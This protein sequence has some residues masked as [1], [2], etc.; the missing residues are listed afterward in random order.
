MKCLILVQYLQTAT[1]YEIHLKSLCHNTWTAFSF[2][3]ITAIQLVGF[4]W[5]LASNTPGFKT[6]SKS[7]FN[8]FWPSDLL[9]N[10]RSNYWLLLTSNS[11]H[12]PIWKHIIIWTQLDNIFLN[13]LHRN[14]A[15]AG[16]GK[17]FYEPDVNDDWDDEDPDDDLE[18]WYIP[19]R[20]ESSNVLFS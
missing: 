2:T 19:L 18:I 7:Y 9:S 14:S 15:G 1:E 17:I 10:Y 6:A 16:R 13:L 12:H 20:K 11:V 4:G 8:F 5:S 3:S